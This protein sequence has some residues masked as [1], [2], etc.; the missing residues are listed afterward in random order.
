MTSEEL[1][2]GDSKQFD[3][4]RQAIE[5]AGHAFLRA[6]ERE[7]WRYPDKHKRFGAMREK[8]EELVN[9]IVGELNR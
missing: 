3:A 2:L 4:T 6:V 1:D 5:E 7:V 8:T 9:S